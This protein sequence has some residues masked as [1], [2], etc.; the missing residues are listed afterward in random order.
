MEESRASRARHAVIEG[1]MPPPWV[2][3]FLAQS[4]K[5]CSMSG[6]ST[7][8]K[9]DF[10]D[11]A[12]PRFQEL[13]E[14][15]R[16]MLSAYE[17]VLPHVL[18]ALTGTRCG[19][20]VTDVNS[21]VLANVMSDTVDASLRG[22]MRLGLD[23]SEEAV[24]TTAMDLAIRSGRVFSVFGE[25]HYQSRVHNLHCV[26]A[27]IRQV[28]G[29]VIGALDVTSE[30]PLPASFVQTVLA[31]AAKSIEGEL[32]DSIQCASR[33]RLS[34]AGFGGA[35]AGSALLAL[36]E[37]GEVLSANI[38]ARKL[39]FRDSLGD[40]KPLIFDD[41]FVEKFGKV[42]D[43]LRNQTWPQP[44]K[45]PSG[46]TV[47]AQLDTPRQED[48]Q[49]KPARYKPSTHQIVEPIDVGDFATEKQLNKALKAFNFDLPVLLT[50][51]TGTGKEVAARWLHDNSVRRNGP[52]VALNCAAIPEGL[53][54]SE[55][56]GYVE[57]AFTGARK[58]GA[59]GKI[60]LANRGTLF[61]DEIGDMR[62]DLQARL[63]R[64][65]EERQTMR[66]GGK[67]SMHVDFHLI[68]AT[69]QNLERATENAAFREDLYYR[70]KG[71][72]VE[73][74]PL[75]A[76][77]R[78]QEF[79]AKLF[80]KEVGPSTRLSPEAQRLL[81]THDWPG[82]IRELRNVLRYLRA[83]AIDVETILPEHLPEE[84]FRNAKGSAQKAANG[85]AAPIKARERELIE[86][87][88]QSCNGNVSAAA[89]MLGISRATLYR[90][91]KA[92]KAA[93]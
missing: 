91:L 55:L 48:A 4:W 65:L 31:T 14:T 67:Q 11:V 72:R 66:L 40:N 80:E 2:D 93:H 51:P 77:E 9:I 8:E 3:P 20:M 32:F 89:Q 35:D 61:L 30:Y 69:H 7:S 56:F 74:K 45:L 73:L 15:N 29:T 27:P 38:A 47:Y 1:A 83:T 5:R 41:I 87:A 25:E 33:I 46:L 39:F 16:A 6:R 81:L 54:E 34:L 76:R 42:V 13:V 19:V 44:L 17:K 84:L 63:L 23:L 50:G 18:Q 28:D 12:R 79:L 57:G 37:D 21:I 64:V 22:A 24:G 53:I 86:D 59:P 49:S 62:I 26:S 78:F 60:E 71:L 90:R 70:I 88:L 52:F 36:G 75:V 85:H 82:N 68:S 10:T 43:K 92:E 58:G